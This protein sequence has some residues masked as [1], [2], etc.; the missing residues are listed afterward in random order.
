MNCMIG[1]LQAYAST[2]LYKNFT[3]EARK[4][5][6]MKRLRSLL[7]HA[8]KNSPF[9]GRHFKNAGVDMLDAATFKSDVSSVLRRI[10]FL[11]RK[12]MLSGFD[13]WFTDRRVT[14]AGVSAF[15]GDL[16]NIGKKFLNKYMVCKTSGTTG[17]P[18]AVLY[19]EHF[20]GIY[21]GLFAS[22]KFTRKEDYAPFLRGQFRTATVAINDGFH[23]GNGFTHRKNPARIL[24]KDTTHMLVDAAMPMAKI[25][26]ALNRFQPNT[27]R[28]FPTTFELLADECK[29]GRLRISPALLTTSGEDLPDKRREYLT[30]AF[31][32][33]VHSS[34]VSTE[35]GVIASDCALRRYHLN[36]DWMIV[37]PVDSAGNPVPDGQ[38]SD[39]LL[40]TVLSNF[41]QP[42]IRY[43]VTDRIRYHAE[44]RC[45]CGNPSP[46]IEIMGRADAIASFDTPGGKIK[47][48]PWLFHSHL[49]EID[50]CRRYQVV[51]RSGNV[52][53]LRLDADDRPAV[54][55]RVCGPLRQNLKAM[56]AEVD[57]RLSDDLPEI[58]AT[59][60]FQ[61]VVTR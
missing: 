29:A 24:L 2:E 36:D 57:V 56:G 45:P 61:C 38:L 19:D 55:A 53:E 43:E 58:D 33:H 60:K 17:A 52:I 26:E 9:Y 6:Q 35:G 51:V 28:S 8:Q 11:T 4:D 31:G 42:F 14:E 16:G 48:T 20:L 54:F 27:I 18:L 39:K 32:C 22:P 7:I 3:D 46:W 59:K 49:M 41:T 13:D 23:V 15:T 10:P 1:F 37:E 47:V 30:E 40:L 50:E 12:E 44:E 25:V 5:I 21:E 34:Y